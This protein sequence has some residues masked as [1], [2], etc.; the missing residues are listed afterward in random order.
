QNQS[1]REHCGVDTGEGAW[2]CSKDPHAI[3]CG[4]IK[5]A[6]NFLQQHL[7][8]DIAAEDLNGKDGSLQYSGAPKAVSYVPLPPPV[9]ARIESDP[10]GP[11][12]PILH[13][14]PEVIKLQQS[15]S[16]CCQ[17]PRSM[18]SA[19]KPIEI[20]PCTIYT[21]TGVWHSTIEVQK[22]DFCSNRVIGPDGRDLGLFNWNNCLLFTHDLLDDYTSSFTSSETPFVAW[23]SVINRRYLTR[24]SQEFVS[25]KMFRAV[26]FSY[27]QLVRLDDDMTC[28]KCGPNPD[29]VIFDGVTL[30]FNRKNLLPT[31][32]PPTTIRNDAK[33]KR[34]VRPEPNLQCIPNKALR[35]SVREILTGPNLVLPDLSSKETL[36]MPVDSDLSADEDDPKSLANKWH[37]AFVKRTQALLNRI[38]AIP[39]AVEK[40]TQLDEHLGKMFDHWFGSSAVI[41]KLEAPAIYRKLFLQIVAEETVLQLING[42][43]MQ[44]LLGFIQ[45]PTESAASEL[46]W[47]PALYHV[48]NHELKSGGL[49]P[50]T[51]GVCKWLYKRAF[52]ALKIL[53]KYGYPDKDFVE[54][55]T[56]ERWQEVSAYLIHTHSVNIDRGE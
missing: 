16:C 14:P 9:W 55:N 26:W 52:T 25:D 1:Y 21:I 22:C 13:T 17:T 11:P 5:V 34:D 44:S 23:V 2:S 31:L 49:G 51:M 8:G 10:E 40:L 37:Q 48:V 36:D 15:S 39:N 29:V 56:P 4:H 12:L 43:A 53:E 47:I 30:A 46:T 32:R 45:R 42:S 27:I 6:R 50:H 3:G 38:D 35:K 7:K 19:S 33:R 28:S 41:T 18:Y 20:R 54:Q 24:Q